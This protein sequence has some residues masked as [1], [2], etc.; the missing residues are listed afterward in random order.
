MHLRLSIIELKTFKTL[1]ATE[2]VALK[3]RPTL[4]LFQDI[5]QPDNLFAKYPTY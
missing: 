2:N 5:D 3:P 1:H 4:M